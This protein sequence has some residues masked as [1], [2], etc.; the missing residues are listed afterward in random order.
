MSAHKLAPKCVCGQPVQGVAFV[1]GDCLG[2]LERALADVPPLLQELETTRLRQS[3]IGSA[4][5]GQVSKHDRPLPWNDSAS[6]RLREL[7]QR[8]AFWTRELVEDDLLMWGDRSQ[9]LCERPC[10]HRS[11]WSLSGIRLP[12]GTALAWS[13]YLLLHS[14]RLAARPDAATAVDQIR[15]AVRSCVRAVDSPLERLYAGPCATPD[16]DS[17]VEC[18]EDLYAIRGAV[19]TRCRGCGAVHVVADRREWLLVAAESQL[20][21]ATE[22]A[23]AVTDLAGIRVTSAMVRGYALR[24]RIV[25]KGLNLRGH[26]TYR[27]GDLLDL[28]ADEAGAKARAAEKRKSTQARRAREVGEREAS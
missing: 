20:A 4:G 23:D 10:R 15:D 8:L 1:C 7:E 26:P 2:V 12:V 24:G 9:P 19:Q 3:R 11:C 6:R 21:T 28:L 18:A 14:R 27:V 17:G 13:E 25:A 5:G 22:L 16:P